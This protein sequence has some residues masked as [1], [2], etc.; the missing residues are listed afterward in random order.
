[1]DGAG[2]LEALEIIKKGE[3]RLAQTPRAD[4]EDFEP[5]EEQQ[6]QPEDLDLLVSSPATKDGST[7]E[8]RDEAAL[9]RRLLEEEDWS[10]AAAA[11]RRGVPRHWLRYRMTK[12]GIQRPR[13][14]KRCGSG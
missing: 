3:Q 6:I 13:A 2:Y 9:L 11:R 14:K 5:C 1:M 7:P 4:M 8:T 10:V 12:Y